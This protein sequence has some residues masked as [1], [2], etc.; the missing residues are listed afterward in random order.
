MDFNF[1]DDQVAIRELAYQ[2]FTDRATDEFLLDFSRTGKTYDDELWQ[3][4]AEQGLLGI[5]VP[6]SAGGTGLG[7]FELCLMLEEQGRRVA[8]VPLFASLVLGGLPLAEFGSA[9]QQQA[10]LGPMA[11]G[12]CKLSAAIA[13]V[14]MNA[15]VA[16]SVACEK[17]GDGYVLN[18]TRAAVPDGA[19]ADY[20]LVP[21]ADSAGQASFF[22]VAAD[23][24]GVTLEG[25]QIGLSGERAAHLSL[26]NVS[27]GPDAL[28]GTEGQGNEILEWLLQRANIG[29]CAMQVGVTEEAMQRTAAYVSERKQF[30]VPLGSFQALA[31]RMA[32][33]YIDVEGMRS[34]YWLALWR[35]SENKD[36]RA[37]VRAAKWW[38]CDAAHRVVHTAQHLHGG[39]GAD[40]EY[41]IHRF[42]LMAKLISY[43]LGNASQQLEELG[44][45]LAEDDSMGF[46]ALEA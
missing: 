1:S 27:V 41:P 46:R 4:L 32:D 8:P 40:V 43:S 12:E 26:A 24:A 33:S 15:A 7:L 21:A 9:E 14:G 44:R 31:M 2:I 22:I 20:I 37:E 39:M 13:E 10:Y 45:L 5:A 23:A 25:V 16:T 35:L 28:L 36:A 29:H 17:S 11:A 6:E 34:T 3:T 38:A 18:G 19:V 30:G 42:F